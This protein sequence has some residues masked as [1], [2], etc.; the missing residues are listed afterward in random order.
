[1]EKNSHRI[2]GNVVD[3]LG[4]R[5][6][7]G[8]VEVA[9]GKIVAVKEDCHATGGYLLPGFVDAH[10]HI[11]SSMLVPSQF[12][13]AAVVHGTVAT[14]SDPHEI[15]NVLGVAG[16]Q[17]MLD[18]AAQ[19]PFK[20]FFGAP[21]CVPATTFET[22]GGTVTAAG[23]ARLLE[24]DRIGYLGE[25][26]NFPGV[27]NRDNQVMA[28]LQ[29]AQRLG[30]PVDG[31]APGLRGAQA[32]A[33]IGAGIT[34]DHE[35]FT[36]EE[37]AEKLSYGAR[38]AIREGSA[39]R[40]FDALYTLLREHPQHCFLCSDDKHP[41]ELIEGHIDVLV[42]RATARGIP[43]FDVLLAACV[44][45]VYHYELNVGLMC[46]GDPADFIEVDSLDQ[47]RV[48]RT[49]IEGTLVAVEGRSTIESREPMVVNKFCAKPHQ[50]AEFQVLA[51][52]SK[53]NVI[54]AIDGQ[55]ITKRVVL[56]PK[57]VDGLA[58][59]DSQRDI[60]KI[61]VVN[62]YQ[63][64]APEIAFIRNFGLQRGAIASS[65]AHD[66]H[67]VIGVGVDDND[68][69]HAVNLVINTGGGLAVVNAEEQHVLP[70]PIAGLMS[71]GSCEEVAQ[72]Y[73]RLNRC[74]EELG[75]RLRAP[76]MTLSF[77][78]L[79]VIPEIKLSDR[80]LFD[81]QSFDFLPLFD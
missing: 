3:V 15:A 27:L 71:T 32:K 51:R 78:T 52:S 7:P 22:S 61:A 24:N 53:L 34:T 1:M 70:L 48:L 23:V 59:S 58:V 80:G 43:L 12:A 45:P 41:D 2:A 73:V 56:E 66:S 26:M 5:I 25:M 4:R 14:V 17:Y 9:G 19:V 11:E 40:N 18:N 47:W 6:F 63:E 29:A 8:V 54:E 57:V 38:I 28:K 13:R 31:H 64:A 75:C 46:P 30:K 42:R 20:F 69:C 77:M 49:Y 74:V 72:A 55:I 50:V 65:V 21:S 10:V 39:A 60:L 76:F 67:N 79:L 35:C 33:Y 81:V 62:R 36:K 16:V 68:L 44:N 37:A